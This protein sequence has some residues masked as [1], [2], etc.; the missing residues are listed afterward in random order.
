MKHFCILASAVMALAV[1]A[2]AQNSALP[3]EFTDGFF[4]QN[5]GWFG[6]ATGSINWVDGAGTVYYNIDD[7][8][9]GNVDVLGNT[10]EYGM[11]YGGYYYAMSKQAPRLVV[12]DALTLK[13]VKSFETIGGDS[14]AVLGVDDGKVYVGTSAG[15]F[16]LDVN[17]DFSISENAIS[18]TE[19]Q[20][21]MMARVGKYV[22]AAKQSTGVLVIDPETDA[23]VT[24]IEDSNICGLTVSRDGTVWAVAKSDIVRINPVTLDNDIMALPNKM[25]SPWGSWMADK[26]CADPDEDAL[27]YAYGGSWTNSETHIGKLIINE[28]GTLS[29]DTDFAYI[30]PD[31]A[32]EGRKQIL[33]GAIGI[34]PQSGYLIVTTTQDGYGA[35]YAYNWL[36]YIDR[37]SGEVAKTVVM[38]SD[39]GDNYYWFPSIP[40]FPDIDAPEINLTDMTLTEGD[41]VTYAVTD[42]VADSDNMPA[43]AVADVVSDDMGVVA[44]EDN[45]G[46]AFTAVAMHEGEASLTVTVNSNGQVEEKVINVEVLPNTVSVSDNLISTINVYPTTVATSLNVKGVDDGTVAVYNMSG[47]IVAMHDLCNGSTIDLGGLIPG[48]YIVKVVSGKDIK[49]VKILKL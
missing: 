9:N 35:N 41:I 33:Y 36:H 26:M 46:F 19:G 23:V 10:S 25:V 39:T 29:E 6:Q 18:G 2:Y 16:V 37:K 28:D 7:K 15:I 42:Y 48:T 34:D 14:R 20:I 13:V 38:T 12:M 24:T 45:N 5:E 47:A 27:Y 40:V 43:L 49:V 8:A 1:G 3:E 32:T 11:V 22:F 17:A 21:G 44:V 4:I 30:M 31:A